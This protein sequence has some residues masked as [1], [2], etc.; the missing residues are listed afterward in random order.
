M[1]PSRREILLSSAAA[2]VAGRATAAATKMTLALHQNTSAGAGYKGSLEGWAKAGITQVELAWGQIDA[3]VKGSSVAAARRVLTDNGLTPVSASLGAGGLIEPNSKRAAVLDTVKAQCETLATLGVKRVYTTT[4][5]A[6]KPTPEAYKQSADHVRELGDIGRQYGLV[7]MVEFVRQSAYASTLTTLLPIM[8]AAAHANTGIVF[9]C[10][11]FW[12]GHN[13]LEDLALLRPGDIGHVHFQD[14]PDIQ[15]ELL[16]LTTRAI[17]GDG[18]SP[19]EAILDALSTK[20]RYAGPL[21]VEL[22]APRFQEGEPSEVA[23][24]IRTK[25]ETV[26]R[27]A[28]VL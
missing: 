3:F 2:L 23:R 10:Y 18:I 21:S 27:R 26:M 13:R 19:L 24:E 16:D 12:S 8:R 14:V 1:P 25:A 11:H 6:M 20:A 4:A 9:D 5:T 15:R 17:P 28:K 7:V 22:F